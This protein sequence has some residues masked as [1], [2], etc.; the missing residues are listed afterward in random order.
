M[1]LKIKIALLVCLPLLLKGG[2]E[3][4]RVMLIGEPIP[5][6]LIIGN[7]PE[8]QKVFL[9][10]ELLKLN[11]NGSFVFGFDRDDKGTH[12]LRVVYE[13]GF[14][15]EIA[16][17]LQKREYQIQRINNLQQQHVT[18]P[19]ELQERIDRERNTIIEARKKI[20]TTQTPYFLSGFMR[21]VEGGRISGVFGSQRILNGEPRNPHNG[22]DIALPTGAPVYAMADGIVCLRADD[23]HY[24]GNFV[25][26]DHGHGLN[27][28]YVHLHKIHVE[29]G[30]H[31]IKGQLIGEVGSTGRSTGPHLHWGVQWY[32]KRIDPQ[33]V[34]DM[35]Y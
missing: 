11:P 12:N 16:L 31:V 24:N 35:N 20:D 17:V 3:P 6:H 4:S 13:D 28:V 30:A 23:F 15:E 5:G 9:N 10:N 2:G 33:A 26:L 22:L 7:A 14:S 8:A 19:P 25:L 1:F 34:L 32:G 29:D 21:P 18:P 27:S